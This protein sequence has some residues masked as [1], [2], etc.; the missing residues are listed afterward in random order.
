MDT[1][2]A[3]ELFADLILRSAR[4]GAS[5]RMAS[6]AVPCRHPSRRRYAPPQDEVRE[7]PTRARVLTLKVIPKAT[8]PSGP[9]IPVAPMLAPAFAPAPTISRRGR[10]TRPSPHRT[11]R[12][13]RPTLAFS[14]QRCANPQTQSTNNE[15]SA[16]LRT[17][18]LPE[19]R[20]VI[21]NGHNEK[22]AEGRDE[23]ARQNRPRGRA[24]TMSAALLVNVAVHPLHTAQE[25]SRA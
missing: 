14:R 23:D 13:S 21:L 25:V 17:P 12:P 11:N 20:P 9:R 24:R 16:K 8:W 22:S 6:D 5:R 19:P 4:K 18:L 2:G 1:L 7:R 10:N 15:C 3:C